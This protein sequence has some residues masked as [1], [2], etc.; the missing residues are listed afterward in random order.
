MSNSLDP[1]QVQYFVG[2]GLSPNCFKSYQQMTLGDK[3]LNF[4]YLNS[5]PSVLTLIFG[6]SKE[7]SH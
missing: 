7:P 5:H 1:D 2:P 4:Q 3:E 6:W